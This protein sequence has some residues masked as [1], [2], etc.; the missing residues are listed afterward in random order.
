MNNSEF[1]NKEKAF[2]FAKSTGSPCR[3]LK[4]PPFL[5]MLFSLK[6]S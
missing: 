6:A 3:S 4:Q 1:T 5:I 2:A